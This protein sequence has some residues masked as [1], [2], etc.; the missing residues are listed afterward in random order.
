M[1]LLQKS[2]VSQSYLQDCPD[3]AERLK[4]KAL[5]VRSEG[6]IPPYVTEAEARKQHSDSPLC[7]SL[8]IASN[9][10][11]RPICSHEGCQIGLSIVVRSVGLEP[12]HLAA[13]DPKSNASTN[14]A[15][16]AARFAS[17][18]VRII[19]ELASVRMTSI[20]PISRITIRRATLFA[21]SRLVY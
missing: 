13:L 15:T 17:A 2:T 10:R 21:A 7:N 14:S 20:L 5:R 4:R 6:S 8:Y 18:K 11:E 9:K 12:T 19:F 3:F 1:R 16:T